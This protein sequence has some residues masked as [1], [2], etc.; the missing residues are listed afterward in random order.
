[1]KKLAEKIR[2]AGRRAREIGDGLATCLELTRHYVLN[3]EAISEM[4]R[5]GLKELI[6]K[7]RSTKGEFRKIFSK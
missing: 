4:A 2:T 6:E 1:M 3:K 7:G 5:I